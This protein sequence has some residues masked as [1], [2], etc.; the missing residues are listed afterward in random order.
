MGFPS[1][2]L[3]FSATMFIMAAAGFIVKLEDHKDTMALE[4]VSSIPVCGIPLNGKIT[5]TANGKFISPLPGWGD[6]SFATSL[7]D[8]SARFYFDQGISMYYSYHMKEALAS[9]REAARFAPLHPMGYWGQAL[10]MGPY[11]NAAHTYTIPEGIPD[12]LSKM[13]EYAG[14]GTPKEQDLIRVMSLRYPSVIQPGKTRTLDQDYSLETKKLIAQYPDDADIKMLYIDGIMLMHAWD[15]WDPD[16]TAREW[17]PEIMTLCEE[18]LRTAPKHPAALH[19]YIHLT[20]ASRNPRLSLPNGDALQSLFPGVAHMVHMS[21]HTY[22]RNGL[23]SKGVE[24]NDLA[25]AALKD[26]ESRAKN[27]SLSRQSSH[28]YAVQTYCALSGGMYREAMRSALRCRES[29][30]PSDQNTYDQYLFMLP[31][32]TRVR[33][34]KWNEILEDT[35]TLPSG[36]IYAGILQHFTKGLALVNTGQI[37]PASEELNMLRAKSTEPLLKK[38]RIPFNAPSQMTAIAENI[39]EAAIY[40]SQKKHDEAFASL[41]KAISIEDQ[42]IYTE[43]HDWPLPARQF[44]GYFLLQLKR[45]ETA[46]KIYAQD[47]LVNPGNGWSMLGMYQSKQALGLTSESHTFQDGYRLAFSGSTL[48]PTA[49]VYWSR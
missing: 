31:A 44:L 47:L 37:Q 35:L 19:Y 43:P 13:T 32:L 45:P 17:T 5:A 48:I 12:V 23:Y 40:F 16:G 25:D 36:W 9:F 22:Q 8:D 27:L 41:E 42:L 15:F 18:V 28:Y 24:V 21:S 33:M 6:Y 4:S 34:G 49:S 1:K 29:V 11:Y 3:L 2:Y 39:L 10:V 46:E 20:E 7:D 38:R 14:K 30:N 26:Y